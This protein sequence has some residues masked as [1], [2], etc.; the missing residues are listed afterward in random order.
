MATYFGQGVEEEMEMSG[1]SVV[2]NASGIF[3]TGNYSSPIINFGLDSLTNV[4]N[5]DIYIVKY[6]ETGNILW[7]K[8]NGGVTPVNVCYCCIILNHKIRDISGNS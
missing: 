7:A 5:S 3:V 2:N 1:V 8:N 6:D 4:G